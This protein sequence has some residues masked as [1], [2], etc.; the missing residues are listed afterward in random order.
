[1][2][3]RER[4]R[5]ISEHCSS[6]VTN[7]LGEFELEGICRL[8]D[9]ASPS[10]SEPR[11]EEDSVMGTFGLK[12]RKRV[13]TRLSPEKENHNAKRSCTDRCS[14]DLTDFPMD[15]DNRSKSRTDSVLSEKPGVCALKTLEQHSCLGD[16]DVFLLSGST[17]P[18]K[19]TLLAS[20]LLALTQSPL[21][22]PPLARRKRVQGNKLSPL[23]IWLLGVTS[24]LWQT[25]VF[26]YSVFSEE[27]PDAVQMT[28]NQELS[29]FHTMVSRKRPLSR[30]YSRKKLLS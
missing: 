5:K 12:S 13:F 10:D 1:S 15:E 14:L 8:Q 25:V 16:D 18:V 29:P 2:T 22:S 26:L 23:G 28:A 9:Q 19:S 24:E 7:T 3:G 20:S 4:A 27:E 6:K 11:A 17:P 30:T 21:L